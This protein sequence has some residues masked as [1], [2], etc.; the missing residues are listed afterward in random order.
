[1]EF[2]TDRR[3]VIGAGVALAVAAGVCLALMLGARGKPADE[4]AAGKSLVIKV[5]DDG[6]LE[7]TRELPCYV[8]GQ[9]I[10]MATQAKC[11]QRNGVSSGQLDVGIDQTGA[12]AYG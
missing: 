9:S 1:M 8:N 12:L 5:G 6:K 11:A 10:G 3:V 2:P 7:A 4:T